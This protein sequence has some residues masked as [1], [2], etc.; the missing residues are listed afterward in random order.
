MAMERW[1]PGRSLRRWGPFRELEDL[2]RH[3]EDVFHHPFLPA[4]WRRLPTEMT[5]APLIEMF[6]K[7][8]KF[9]VRAE[10]PGMKKEDIDVSLAGST[11]IIKGE[12]KV[13]TEVKEEEYY[14]CERSYGSFFRSIALPS[15]V[16]VKKIEAGY[17]DGVL[18]VTLPK[19]A[20]AK[21]KKVAVS[22]KKKEKASK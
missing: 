1:R 21:P 12:R 20:E 13:E 5:W 11:L 15:P 16:D 18:E 10:L 6:E 9:M 17:E 2:T 22:S 19:A 7:E 14:C 3:F 8:D 4:V